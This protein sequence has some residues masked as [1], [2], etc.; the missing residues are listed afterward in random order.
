MPLP[1]HQVR[2]LFE[3]VCELDPKERESEL[4]KRCKDDPALR[5]EV[6]SL[7]AASDAAP[8]FFETPPGAPPGALTEECPIGRRVGRYRIDAR[9]ASGGMGTV[10]EATRADE[11]YDQKV[12]LKLMAPHTALSPG[13]LSR[14]RD[15]RQT[16]ANL[17][18]AN[19]A[20]L[21]DGGVADDGRPY[22][23]MEYVDGVPL[24][25]YCDKQ[26]LTTTR[27][28]RLFRTV[29]AAV[30][31][32]H[33]NLVVHRDLKPGNIL[34]SR[35]GVVK[36]VDFGIAKILQADNANDATSTLPGQRLMTPQYASPEQIRGEPVTTASD[37]YS[38]GVI[39]YELLTGHRPYRL[40]GLGPFDIERTIRETD[41][42]R[43]SAVVL[44]SEPLLGDD[45]TTRGTVTP[46]AVS[47]VRD[48]QP[49]ALR[50]RLAGDLDAIVFKAMRSE[51]QQRY[52]SVERLSD[53]IFRHLEGLPVSARRGTVRYRIG[54]F[55]RRNKTAVIA[56]ATGGAAILA[57]M[58][59]VVRESRIAA[60]QRDQAVAARQ[61]TLTEALKATH[62]NAFLQD[63]LASVDPRAAGREV[64]VRAALDQASLRVGRELADYPQVQAGIRAVIGRSYHSLGDYDAALPHLRTALALRR[65][66]HGSEHAEVGESMDD[67]GSL[68]TSRGD[69]D[70]AEPLLR[71][72]LALRRRLLGEKSLEVA[73]S[74]TNLGK[75]LHLR[76]D[77]SAAE[78]LRRQ[79][80]S[81]RQTHHGDDHLD[82]ASSM[83][84]L[85]T[86]LQGR[87][88]IAEAERLYRGALAIYVKLVGRNHSDVSDVLNNLA[89]LLQRSGRS[90]LAEPMF[91]ES[92]A[93]RREILGD[94]HPNVARSLSNLAGLLGAKG[95]R[96]AAEPLLREA[97]AI[98]RKRLGE[99]HPDVAISL[100]KLAESVRADGKAEEAA[101]FFG[102]A[103][104]IADRAWPEGHRF[105][106]E[107]H[108]NYGACL[109]ELKRY[110]EAESQLR[111]SHRLCNRA[112]DSDPDRTRTVVQNLIEL[113]TSWGKPTEAAAWT[114]RLQRINHDGPSRASKA[115]AAPRA[116]IRVPPGEPGLR[117]ESQ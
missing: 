105:R 53:D 55:I 104:R 45:G 101:G 86:V 68:L 94:D 2:A 10:Y 84:N 81:I 67:L 57:G 77:L 62:I 37:I 97:L 87:G 113:Y 72:G 60:E 90:D 27:R 56:A 18:H 11:H 83:T 51:P 25:V 38:L 14:F 65:D 13:A 17:A 23:V 76:G 3:R 42:V 32:A 114:A 71:G 107:F 78:P 111:L 21:L 74:L 54:K 117:E 30:Q 34:V 31:F 49:Q 109:T 20:R 93:I 47:R 80:L 75:L 59:A 15:E 95:D 63:M 79:A 106:A 116:S 102:E 110:E 52:I 89:S 28:L 100:N 44:R 40:S 36:L 108:R 88:R 96:K 99:N 9:I 1:W 19:I 61:R 12:A 24:D 66:A 58:V 91:R 85:A 35:D 64:T 48:G 46:E 5:A 98:R 50:R 4:A 43:P 115:G 8:A 7:L 33:R 41:P 92:L 26:R 103:V 16:L 82:V 73:T 29:C 22:L 6:E 69:Y 112:L 70:E 39:L